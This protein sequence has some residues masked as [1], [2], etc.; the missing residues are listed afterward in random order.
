ME[1]KSE[2]IKNYLIRLIKNLPVVILYPI[3]LLTLPTI[4][5]FW[6]NQGVTPVSTIYQVIGIYILY[7]DEKYKMDR[8]V[9]RFWTLNS[10]LITVFES[11]EW[12][13]L[14][15]KEIYKIVVKPSKGKDTGDLRTGGSV[16]TDDYQ[17]IPDSKI[18][19]ENQLKSMETDLENLRYFSEVRKT[20]Y[21]LIAIGYILQFLISLC[22]MFSLCF[23]TFQ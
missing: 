20:G 21:I 4:T 23:C 17:N 5:L 10:W 15:L 19:L 9:R 6:Y 14:A 2:K 8:I 13:K 12:C 16:F 7:I 1:A 11:W 18:K 3:L 22:L